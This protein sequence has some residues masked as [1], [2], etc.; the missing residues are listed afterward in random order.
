MY[1]KQCR[2][3][4]VGFWEANWSGSALLAKAGYIRVP[5]GQGWE[6]KQ[7]C[8]IKQWRSRAT[9]TRTHQGQALLSLS[10]Y[11]VVH[12]ASDGNKYPDDRVANSWNLYVKCN[13]RTTMRV[14]QTRVLS[15]SS[16][17]A[18][19]FSVVYA[20]DSFVI[21]IYLWSYCKGRVRVS[22]SPS[23]SHSLNTH[24]YPHHHTPG[25]YFCSNFSSFLDFSSYK[26]VD[27]KE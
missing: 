3:R 4:S 9:C 17:F 13:R 26:Q 22:L 18:N 21:S 8:P 10:I 12:T 20:F 2:S 19:F 11:S 6:N 24:H 5:Q 7:F 1:Y 15:P 27:S 25:R 14:M 23:L 16:F